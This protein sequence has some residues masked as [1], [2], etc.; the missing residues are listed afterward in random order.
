MGS[1]LHVPL[2]LTRA[3]ETASVKIMYKTT[4][5]CPALMWLE[6]EYVGHPSNVAH[7]HWRNP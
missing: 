4:E 2:P 3:G 7:C 6:K 5:A 1:A